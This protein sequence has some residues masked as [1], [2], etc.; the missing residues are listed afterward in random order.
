MENQELLLI[1]I[2]KTILIAS[3]AFVFIAIF[4]SLFATYR[5][6][7]P[8]QWLMQGTSQIR[9]GNF[10]HRIPIRTN[11]ELGA[12]SQ[13]FNTMAGELELK[14]RYRSVLDLVTDPQVAK[15]L[16]AGESINL[17]GEDRFATVLFCDIR[18]FTP[19]SED[20]DPK[21]L[22]KQLND[23]MNAL[24]QIVHKYNGVVDKFVGDEIMALFGVPHTYGEDTQSAIACSKEMLEVCKARFESGSEIQ[25][26]VGLA[27]GPLVAGCIGS[28]DRLNYTVIGKNVNL[29][30]RLCSN[31]APGTCLMDETTYNA[32]RNDIAL[33][34]TPLK[35]KGFS[36][37]VTAY[38]YQS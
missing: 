37:S 25:V 9:S 6:T 30:S 4:V 31:A 24:T 11:D 1:A 7:K 23:H 19:W 36:H 28:K 22:V 16:T 15:E 13:Q 26:G 29:A 14:E 10:K 17:G 33:E 35:L 21:E 27:T 5:F 2:Q 32:I 12:L 8:I 38:L 3:A 18:N 20:L 34:S